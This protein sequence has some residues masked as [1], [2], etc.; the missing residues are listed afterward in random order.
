MYVFSLEYTHLLTGRCWFLENCRNVAG[1]QRHEEHPFLVLTNAKV[2][3]INTWEKGA[4]HV[5]TF[6]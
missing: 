3:W 2:W 6:G 4:I 1:K 5:F